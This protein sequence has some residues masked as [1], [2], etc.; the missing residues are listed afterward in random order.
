MG[1]LAQAECRAFLGHRHGDEP[2]NVFQATSRR[3][4]GHFA[5]ADSLKWRQRDSSL[6]NEQSLKARLDG[7]NRLNPLP[8]RELRF[9]VNCFTFQAVSGRLTR[10]EPA[11]EIA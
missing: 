2:S 8:N 3:D 5:A 11:G 1:M 6:A 9:L 7:R 10:R 4:A